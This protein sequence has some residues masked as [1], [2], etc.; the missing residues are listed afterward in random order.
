MLPD[1]I[2]PML[3][4]RGQPFTSDDCLFEVKWDGTRTIVFV[5]N[6]NYRLVNRRRVDM[7][8]RYPEF[9]FLAGLP[10]GTVLDGEM[11]VLEAG[12]PS[13]HKLL[14]R[15][16][17]GSP[18]KIRSLARNMP[19]VLVVFDQ[20]YAGSH[21]IMPQPLELRRRVLAETVAGCNSNRLVVSDV[22]LGQGRA[23]FDEVVKRDLEGIMAKRLGSRYLAGK[24]TDAWLKIK[25]RSRMLCAVM[26]FQPAD[27]GSRDFRSLILASNDPRTN[28]L[29]FVGKV[30]T[31]FPQRLRNQINELVW[32]RLQDRPVVP[33]VEKGRWVE[34]GLFCE[35]SYLEQ[36]A[37]GELRDPVFEKLIDPT[38][39]E[40]TA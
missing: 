4:K 36:T 32:S 33:C 16:N 35:V 7:T 23:L 14:S 28:R 2:P 21:S 26:G 8:Y 30:G 20:L 24:R 12:R 3:A 34:P 17:A 9:D 6:G 11:I 27:D 13:F 37:G 25:K 1:F 38:A 31:G 39:P 18:L 22:V 10:A 19:A 40:P 29:R 5:E 15:E